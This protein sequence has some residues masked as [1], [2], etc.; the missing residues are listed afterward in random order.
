MFSIRALWEPKT[1]IPENLV[2]L[3]KGVNVIS[4]SI[5]PR[6]LLTFWAFFVILLNVIKNIESVKKCHILTNILSI[7]AKGWLMEANLKQISESPKN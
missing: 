3:I 2:Y 6:F 5:N 7:F 4:N 1:T